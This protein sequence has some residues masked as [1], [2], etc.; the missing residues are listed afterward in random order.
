LN[1]LM[2]IT[3]AGGSLGIPGLYVTGDPGAR[4]EAA[5]RG[6]LSMNFGLGFAKAHAFV[7][8]QSPTMKYHRGLMEAILHDR[9][10]IAKAVNAT[11]ISLDEAPRGYA[12]F[13]SGVAK[14]FVIDP[15]GMIAAWQQPALRAPTTWGAKA[16]WRVCPVNR[17]HPPR[18][19]PE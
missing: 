9:V 19:L 13:D 7:T 6:S 12:D 2:E 14:K 18:C 16:A 11:V 3:R 15:H 8:G 4:E 5:R 10:Q 1:S 17:A